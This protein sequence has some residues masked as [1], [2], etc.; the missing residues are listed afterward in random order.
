MN[1]YR[2]SRSGFSIIE[3]SVTGFLLVVLSMLISNA[4]I[5]IGRPLIDTTYR[6]R[7]AQESSL[8][9]AC[10]ARD[11]GGS[12]A[13]NSA[14]LGGKLSYR[15]VGRTQPGGNE[16]WLCYDGG[17]NPNGVADWLS[18]DVVVTYRIV[19]NTL[20]RSNNSSG[21]EFLV[22]RYVESLT[23]ADRGGEV[24]IRLSFAYHGISQSYLLV[25][26]DP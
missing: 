26:K 21:D 18:P 25:A 23:A 11:F 1:D 20:V 15:L 24:E 9:Q 22:A 8:A 4:W 17:V 14:A 6:C 16:L 2:S 7:V 13:D 12:L 10:L 5:G 19:D 3:V